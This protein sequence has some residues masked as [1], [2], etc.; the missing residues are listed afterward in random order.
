[1]SAGLSGPTLSTT[2][3]AVRREN[4]ENGAVRCSAMNPKDSEGSFRVVSGRG[5]VRDVG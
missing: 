1:M 4:G 5:F 3:R 2:T